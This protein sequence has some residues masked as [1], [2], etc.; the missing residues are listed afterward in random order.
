[1]NVIS[2]KRIRQFS[3]ICRDAETPL[4]AW[5][6]TA[7]KASWKNLA[8]L[9]RVY[10]SADLVGR[11]TVFNIKGNKYRLIARVIYRSQTVFIVAIL[12]HKE[13]DLGKWKE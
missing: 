7:K 11:Y 10:P 6:S 4:R 12:K 1:M 8:D 5:Y 9:K 3:S 2:Y 13:Y